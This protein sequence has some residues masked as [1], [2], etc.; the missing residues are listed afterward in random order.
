VAELCPGGGAPCPADT[1]VPNGTHCGDL[2]TTGGTCQNGQCSGGSPLVCDDDDVCNGLETCDS[3]TG[4]VPGQPLDCSDGN[5]C[6]ADACSPTAGCSNPVLPDGSPCD[7]GQRCTLFDSCTAGTC[8]GTDVQVVAIQNARFGTLT[9]GS[10]HLA[11]ND[12]KGFVKFSR[13][14]FMADGSLVQANTI[15]LSALASLDDVE[16]NKRTGPGSVRGS[17]TPLTVP[18]GLSCAAPSIT[19]GTTPVV[20]PD[21]AVVRI[22]PGAYGDVKIGRRSTLELE[23]GTYDFCTLK[24]FPPAA[25]RP[26][27]DVI[28]RI[29]KDLKTSRLAIFEPY[30]GVL[31]IFVGGKAKFGPEAVIARTALSAPAGPFQLSRMSTFDGA[32]CALKIKAQKAVHFGCPLP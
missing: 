20:V 27:G 8:V 22:S 6:T 28:L 3:L 29:A 21:T 30:V 12:A 1:L 31:Q 2:C 25:I 18:L 23:P 13:A 16:T 15:S 10:G 11:V 19:C 7:D 24:T 14:G 32:A 26:R 17:Q 4:C 5:P 9:E